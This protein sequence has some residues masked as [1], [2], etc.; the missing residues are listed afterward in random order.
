M[1]HTPGSHPEGV[2]LKSLS[3]KGNIM[4]LVEVKVIQ[5]VFNSEEKSDIIRRI[6]E[7]MVDIE[8]E[9]L[10]QVTTVIIEEVLS[11]DWGI[12]GNALSTADVLALQGR[13]TASLIAG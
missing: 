11:G 12:G 10:R 5:G 9:N 2:Q 1:P 3:W 8:G 7:T 4:P 13:A 6:T